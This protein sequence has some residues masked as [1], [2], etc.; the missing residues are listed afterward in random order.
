MFTDRKDA[1]F[2]LA[3]E[4]LNTPA[5]IQ[6]DKSHLL[7]LSIPRGGVDVGHVVARG[8]DCDHDVIAAKK[9]GFP[10]FEEM[11]VGAIVEDGPINLDTDLLTQNDL[12]EADV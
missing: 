7:V 9:I 5:K 12:T 10:G 11:A 2:H 4:L 3:E 6:A 1:G 8:L